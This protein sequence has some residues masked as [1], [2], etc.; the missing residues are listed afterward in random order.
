MKRQIQNDTYGGEQWSKGQITEMLYNPIYTGIM[1]DQK[2]T[3]EHEFDRDHFLRIAMFVASEHGIQK[4]LWKFLEDLKRATPW[5]MLVPVHESYITQ[6]LPIL[7]EDQF[8]HAGTGL[9]HK[10][11]IQKY[12]HKVLDNLAQGSLFVK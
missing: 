1:V 5:T 12:L 2:L 6:R 10:F 4:M 3:Q 9:I 8:V 7:S 11:G